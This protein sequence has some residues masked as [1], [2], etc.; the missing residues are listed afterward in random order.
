MS[1]LFTFLFH[2][3]KSRIERSRKTKIGTEVAHVTL[4]WDNSFKDKRSPCRFTHRGLNASGS[5]SDERGNVL[6]VGNYCYVAVCSTA[7]GASAPTE[8]GEGRD[9]SRR[10]PTYRLLELILFL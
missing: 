5:C 7:L 2:R 4:D 1:Y 8:E 6:G 3:A 10:P 9:I